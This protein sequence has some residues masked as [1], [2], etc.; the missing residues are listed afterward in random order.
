[1]K[2]NNNIAATLR[3]IASVIFVVLAAGLSACSGGGGGSTPVPASYTV[4]GS[5]S[6][7]SGSVLL[8]NN[9]G[10]NLTVSANTGFTFAS[11]IVNGSSYKVTVLTQP[12]GQSCSVSSGTGA[13]S[14]N[15]TSVTVSCTNNSYTVGGSVSG[16]SGSVVLQDNGGDSLTVSTNAGFTFATP[17]TN[18]NTYAATVLTQPIGQTCSVSTG[19]GTISGSNV[20]NVLVVCSVNTY[21]VGGT[22]SGLTGAVVLR[23]NGGDNL[24]VSANGSFTFATPVANAS[25]YSV[26]VFTQPSVS[27][28]CSVTGGAG[29]ITLANVTNVA[30]TCATN[31]YTIG[32]TVTGLSGSMVL[33]DNGGDNLTLAVNGPFTFATAVAHG[34][35]YNVTEFSRQFPDQT[36]TISGGSGTTTANVTTVAVNCV[37]YR[38]PRFAY[39]ANTSDNTVSIYT[40]DATTGQLRARG[41]VPAGTGP[42]SVSVDPSGKFAYVANQSSNNVSVYSINASTG[43]LTAGT[44]VA[45]GTNP[46]SVSVDPSGKFA[47]VANA[48]S[49][50]VS[51]YSID[52]STGA[53]TAG[54]PVAAGTAPVSV[55]TTGTI[56]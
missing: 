7:L 37:K 52:A 17:I 6:G 36:C 51:V 1:M 2:A 40:V 18:G 14:A 50:N 27:Q 49:N 25:P 31:T 56:Q 8:Q 9:G 55:T 47:Y 11:A 10:D 21:T 26:T 41:Y 23:D 32:G 13:V 53:L 35:A 30:I 19:A 28:S 12:T 46:F 3:R 16:L 43:A 4:G 33:Q 5:V 15:V 39:V 38:T 29:T 20:T 34:S 54:T 24:T 45:S 42:Y 48:N 44:P 22:I